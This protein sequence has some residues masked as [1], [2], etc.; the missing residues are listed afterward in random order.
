TGSRITAATVS[1]PSYWRISSRCPAGADGAW[2][3]MAGRATVGERIEHP[4]DAGNAGLGGPAARGTPGR[5]RAGGRAAVAALA[6]DDLVSSRV[7][8]RELDRVLVRL[9]SAVSEERHRDVARR[10]LGEQPRERRPRLGRHRRA[11]RAELVGLLLDRRDEL[12]M[13]VA[14]RDVDE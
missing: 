8:P 13:L 10:H 9:G 1:G 5:G 11:D 6:G 14:D 4:H 12:R 7:P 2:I 3:G